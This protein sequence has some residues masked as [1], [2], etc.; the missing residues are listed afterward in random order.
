MWFFHV[1]WVSREVQQDTDLGVYTHQ[2]TR[3]SPS[4][5][6]ATPAV[7][8]RLINSGFHIPEKFYP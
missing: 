8:I 4:V 7:K 1:S 2:G 6:D 3:P 5:N